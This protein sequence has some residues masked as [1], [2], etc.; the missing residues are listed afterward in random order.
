MGCKV[1]SIPSNQITCEI[2]SSRKITSIHE[3]S[4]RPEC[5]VLKNE[6]NFSQ[7]Y[8]IGKVLGVGKSGEVRLC[9][10]RE[11]GEK[12]A[13][14]IFKKD[15]AQ[16]VRDRVFLEIDI[17][18]SLDH[19][20][21]VRIHE[22]FENLTRIY[23]VLEYCA[24][25]E[26]FED[27]VKKVM[28][29]EPQ[30]MKI[31]RQL[32]TAVVYM[33]ENMIVHRDIKPENI[34][35]E[36]PSDYAAIKIID[37]GSACKNSA[38]MT[39]KQGTIYY[40]SPEVIKGKYT[41]LC[42]VWSLGI[43]LY[44]L[45]SGTLPFLGK[46]NEVATKISRLEIDYSQEVWTHVS[47]EGKDLVKQMLSPETSRISAA[48]ALG[49]A[50]F[51]TYLRPKPLVFNSV[52][53]NITKFH[54]SSKFKEAV[55]TYLVTQ[56]VHEKEIRDL[57]EIFNCLDKNGDGK[58]SREEIMQYYLQDYGQEEA[59]AIVD[60]IIQNLDSDKNG[61]IDYFEFLAA[62]IDQEKLLSFQNLKKAFSIFDADGSGKISATELKKVLEHG[63]EADE[64]IWTE[65]ISL[66]NS[67]E[68][69]IDLDQFIRILHIN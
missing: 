7:V 47:E 20:N 67:A 57:N 1:S 9:Y 30:A 33:H 31:L 34:L 23:V 15:N 40:M 19:P 58:L 44:L 29:S 62:T 59:E 2:G 21:I 26:L 12:R 36:D 38:E 24:G 13:V 52:L 54:Y 5:F 65:F 25:G 27:L 46:E 60:R 14:K 68:R 45:L 39:G 56:C 51:N 28:F 64:K 8:R 35:L 41:K 53:E 49:H 22:Y 17:M 10:Y 32:L 43:V 63:P 42:D 11:T 61:F 4:I 37:F 55:S 16:A 6:Y 3:L 50:W 18:K 48:N 66:E 69:E